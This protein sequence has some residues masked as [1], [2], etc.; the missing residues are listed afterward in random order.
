MLLITELKQVH[1]QIL[2][3]SPPTTFPHQP[4]QPLLLA[5]P[6]HNKLPST[7]LDLQACMVD[8]ELANA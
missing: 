3:V 6:S 8:A 1:G 5:R 2:A 7:R 4:I